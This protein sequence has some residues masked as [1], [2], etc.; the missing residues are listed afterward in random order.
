MAAFWGMIF[1]SMADDSIFYPILWIMLIISLFVSV[2]ALWKWKVGVRAGAEPGAA[3]HGGGSVGAR[4]IPR[5]GLGALPGRRGRFPAVP[6]QAQPGVPGQARAWAWLCS[7]LVDA[8]LSLTA[9]CAHIGWE[10]KDVS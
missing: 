6:G 2:M 9:F 10:A 7:R 3:I 1:L 5:A 4:A 8:P